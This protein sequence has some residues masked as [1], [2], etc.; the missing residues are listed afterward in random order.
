[1]NKIYY[2]IYKI[3]CTEGSFKDK[4]Y[5]GAHKTNDLND[6]YIG[7]GKKLQ[8]YLKKYPNGYIKEILGFYNSQEELNKAEFEFIHPHLGKDYCLNLTEGGGLRAFPGELHPMYG[9]HHSE[10]AKQKISDYFK[11]KSYI[12]DEGR[13]KISKIHKGKP[14]SEQQK[15]KMSNALKGHEVSDETRQKISNS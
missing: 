12:T 11:G 8:K 5:F 14:K 6:G 9:K 10:E 2:Y 13:E 15:Q 7:S 3:T 4:I 1:M